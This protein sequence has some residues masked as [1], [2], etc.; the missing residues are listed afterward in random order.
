M[1]TYWFLFCPQYRAPPIKSKRAITR[2]KYSPLVQRKVRQSSPSSNVH[3]NSSITGSATSSA[4]SVRHTSQSQLDQS[5]RLSR[6]G[7]MWYNH[8]SYAFLMCLMQM[9]HSVKSFHLDSLSGRSQ[10]KESTS[11]L[12]FNRGMAGRTSLRASQRAIQRSNS[13]GKQSSGR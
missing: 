6:S 10:T 1:I 3:N 9:P 12:G 8:I 11:Q 2:E 5:N 7:S 13:P 4:G